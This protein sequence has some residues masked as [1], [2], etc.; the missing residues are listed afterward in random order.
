MTIAAAKM[1]KHAIVEKPISMNLKQGDNMI[2]VCERARVKLGGIF[3]HR[4]SKT[5][6]KVKRVIE[7]DE[8]GKLILAKLI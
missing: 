8:M 1:G 6:Q 3:Q 4:F 7:E 2:D 5:F